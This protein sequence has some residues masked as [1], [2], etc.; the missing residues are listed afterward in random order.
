M[1]ELQ[2]NILQIAPVN[3][4]FTGFHLHAFTELF[5]I[6]VINAVVIGFSGVSYAVYRMLIIQSLKEEVKPQKDSQAKELVSTNLFFFLYVTYLTVVVP[7]QSMH[8]HFLAA[9]FAVI[10]TKSCVISI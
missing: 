8:C 2:M 3:C 5:V 4:L 1:S 10:T 9:N 6:M 7:R